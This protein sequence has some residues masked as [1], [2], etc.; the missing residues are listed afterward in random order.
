MKMIIMAAL[1][2]VASVSMPTVASA[3][4]LS[5]VGTLLTDDGKAVFNFNLASTSTVKI[6]SLGYAGGTNAAGNLIAAGGFDPVLSLYDSSGQAIDF[7]DDGIGAAFDPV[8]GTASDSSLS[9]S[10]AA[11]KYIVYLTQYDNFG[12]ANLA[13]PFN[14]EGQPN[15]RNGFVDFNGYQRTGNWALDI[16]GVTTAGAVPEPATWM[17]MLLGF[18]AV[19]VAARR[20]HAV[21]VTF[22]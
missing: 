13:L 21:R 12:P 6:R 16:N 11:G 22:G 15:F 17:L 3:A 1:A 20:R 9:L 19:G 14:F 8:S 5:F 7:N 4:D 18:A 10:L 2:G